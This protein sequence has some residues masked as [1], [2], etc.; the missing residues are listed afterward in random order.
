MPMFTL[1]EFLKILLNG[2][3]N[4]RKKDRKIEIQHVNCPGSNLNYDKGVITEN[5]SVCQDMD[6][7][8]ERLDRQ[9]YH[10]D[11]IK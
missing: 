9:E 7:Q 5:Y 6:Q 10:V 1:L 3:E 8:F 11:R 4:L 2:G